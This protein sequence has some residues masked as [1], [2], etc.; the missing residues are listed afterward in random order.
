MLKGE[1]DT[2]FNQFN[3]T[4]STNNTVSFMIN[5]V[6]SR[7]FYCRQ[8]V[9]DSHC[10]AG[11]I[12]GLNP[13]G[14]MSQFIANVH[15]TQIL[16]TGNC[17]STGAEVRSLLTHPT[18]APSGVFYTGYI[19]RGITGTVI[20]T[21]AVFPAITSSAFNLSSLAQ[22]S[23]SAIQPSV[24]TSSAE[25]S[26]LHNLLIQLVITFVCSFSYFFLF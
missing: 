15:G 2:G 20:S 6:S 23:S 22:T 16:V 24:K 17:L 21:D 14:H 26:A 10:R 7:W 5:D 25:A 3:P 19:R 12:F 13:S 11:M 1:F 18:S 8:V 9:P 4:D